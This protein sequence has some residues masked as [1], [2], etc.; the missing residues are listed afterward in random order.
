MLPKVAVICANYN[1]GHYVIDGIKSIDNQT[2]SGPIKLFVVDDGST[3]DSWERLSEFKKGKNEHASLIDEEDKYNFMR[4]KNSGASVARNVA[5]KL[6]WNW[7]DMFAILDA[8]DSYYPTKIEK[9][10]SKLVEHEEIGVAYADYENVHHNFTKR[11]FKTAY[12]KTTL[13]QRCIVHS[14]SII[15]K[16]YLE[17]V[18]LPNGEFFD[19]KLHGPASEGFIGCTEDYDLWLRLSN[20]CVMAHVPECLGIANQHENN[21]SKKMTPEIFMEHARIMGSR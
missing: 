1:Y 2:Y 4:I 14:N 16:K 3:D 7:A 12:D 8:D 13:M 15:K 19:S 10:V 11:E 21:Q 20:V 9:L 17:M 5:I 6:A 18:Q